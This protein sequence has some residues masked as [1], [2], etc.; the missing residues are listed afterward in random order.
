MA[1]QSASP[2]S[3]RTLMEASAKSSKSR[4]VLSLDLPFHEENVDKLGQEAEKIL[5]DTMEYACAVKF[6]FH[7]IGPL[8]LDELASL[9]EI[10]KQQGLPSIA[11]LKLNDI[12]NTNRVATEYLWKA[13]F[14]AV[15]VNPFVG[16]NGGLDGV[17]SRARE[18]RKGVITLAYMSHKG[19]SEGYGLVLNDGRTL[20]ELFLDRANEWRADGIVVG[21][22]QEDKIRFA[23]KRIQPEIK[24]Y[25][26]GSGAQGGDPLASLK[27]GSDYIIV[28]RSIVESRNP[29]EEA[30]RW[31]RSL[32]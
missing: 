31:F 16:Y 29:R 25:S 4:I 19:A 15:I 13:G 27:A 24:I 12:D 23:R 2:S 8:S 32:L 21:S 20:F 28:G 18:L 11:D 3:F 5:R 30:S 26:P 22:T 10:I 14:S 7:L 9:N 1:E 6:N 17:I